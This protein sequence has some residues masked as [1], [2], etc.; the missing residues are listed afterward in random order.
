M[1]KIRLICPHCK[2]YSK[3]SN[4]ERFFGKTVEFT[5]ANPG[6]KKKFDHFFQ[7]KMVDD[8]TFLTLHSTTKVQMQLRVMDNQGDLVKILNLKPINYVLGRQHYTDM[9]CETI[10]FEDS[11]ISRKHCLLRYIKS[12]AKDDFRFAISDLNSTNK[13][14]LNKTELNPEEEIYL[15]DGDIINI[16][17]LEIVYREVSNNLSDESIEF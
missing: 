3:L 6:C 13:T 4:P 7:E 17:R 10:L 2:K 16:G 14:F 15:D 8:P 1:K 9:D 12:L 11:F 5:C